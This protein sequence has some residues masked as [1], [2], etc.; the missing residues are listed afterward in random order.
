MSEGYVYEA[1]NGASKEKLPVIFAIQDNGYG[2]SVPK[3]DQTATRKVANNF[4][5]FKNLRVIHCN[6]KDVFDSMNAMTEAK[7]HA[8]E[9]EEPVMVQANCVRMRSHSNSDRHELYRSEAE[10][11]YVLDYDPLAKYRR[12]LIRYERFT[13]EELAAIEADAKT[14]VKT[15]HKAALKSSDPD[16]ESI[17]DFVLPE[18]YESEKYPDGLHEEDGEKEK[19]DYWSE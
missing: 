16:P 18:A 1:I 12:M 7:R 8:L 5:S 15:A 11:N 3:K 17:F 14:I 10:R 4:N 2:I 6:G 9:A 13:E 19:V